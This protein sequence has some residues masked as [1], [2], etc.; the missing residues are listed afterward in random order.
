MEPAK[1]YFDD[2]YRQ[3]ACDGLQSC[4]ETERFLGLCRECELK[5]EDEEASNARQKQF[6]E[7]FKA[8]FF[9]NMP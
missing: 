4:T 8:K 5:V 2:V 9:P 1:Q 3:M 6:F 7:R